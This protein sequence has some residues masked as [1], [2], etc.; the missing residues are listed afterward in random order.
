MIKTMK[1]IKIKPI[2][3]IVILVL[4]S[5]LIFIFTNKEDSQEGQVIWNQYNNKELGFSISL[6]REVATIYRCSNIKE[7]ENVPIKVFNGDGLA[8]LALEYY[9]NEDCEKEIVS[10]ELLEELPKSFFG[11]KLNMNDVNSEDD[12]LD[13]LKNDFGSSCIINTM[14]ENKSG[15]YKITLKGSDWSIEDGWGNCLINYTYSI[16]YSKEKNKLMSV[17]LGQECTFGTYPDSN[18][19]YC[20]DNDMIKSFDFE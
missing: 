19:Y 1:N 5:I 11:W 20:Y 14:E 9:Y 8:Y 16:L 18:P 3:I 4:I 2:L 15:D 13:I 10:E 12:I 7:K 6:P 17:V